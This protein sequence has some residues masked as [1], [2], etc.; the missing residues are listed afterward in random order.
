ML[1]VVI[2][3]QGGHRSGKYGNVRE[4][5][6]LWSYHGN[7]R[8]FGKNSRKHGGRVDQNACPPFS[9]NLEFYTETRGGIYGGSLYLPPHLNFHY[10]KIFCFKIIIV[11]W[12]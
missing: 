7:I 12:I 6:S 5:F 1:L 4:F 10:I 8:E 3:E 11:Y 9:D 2:N